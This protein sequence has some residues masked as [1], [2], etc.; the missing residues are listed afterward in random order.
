MFSLTS[1]ALKTTLTFLIFSVLWIAASDW[2]VSFFPLE[3]Q[4]GLQ[5]SKGLIFVAVTSLLIY[6][7]LRF[8]C[9]RALMLEEDLT[10]ALHDLSKAHKKKLALLDSIPISIWDEDYST[11][12]RIIDE[13]IKPNSS[14]ALRHWLD[15]NALAVKEMANSVRINSIGGKTLE[16]FGISPHEI[17]SQ[18]RLGDIFTEKSFRWFK[19]EL[20]AFYEGRNFLNYEDELLTREGNKIQTSTSICLSNSYQDTWES[21]IVTIEDI[22]EKNE[23]QKAIDSF[24]DLD[25]NLHVIVAEDGT[26]LRVNNGWK[27]VL[28]YDQEELVGQS[29]LNLLHPED[30]EKTIAEAK[31]V[32]TGKKTPYFENRFCHKNGEYRYLAWSVTKHQN[33]NVIYAVASDISERKQAEEKLRDAALIINST[34]EGVILTNLEG[35]I[36]EVNAAFTDITGYARDEAIGK[37]PSLLRSGRHDEHFYRQLW[38]EVQGYGYWRGEIWNRKKDGEIY[39]ELLTINRVINQ[40]GKTYGYAGIF[41][42]ISQLKST[43]NRL[44]HL[45]THDV[46]TGLA[47]RSLFQDHLDRAIKHA[48]RTS[49]IVAVILLDL[50]NFKFINDSLGFNKGDELLKQTADRIVSVVRQDDTVA[51]ISSDE[52]A[53]LLEDVAYSK[54]IYKI[55]EQLLE[56]LKEPFQIDSSEIYLT[57]SAGISLYPHDSENVLTLIRN[58]DTALTCA[59]NDGTGRYQFYSEELTT[60]AQENLQIENA[61]R[62]ALKKNQLFLVYQPQ[63]NLINGHLEGFEVLLRW[64]HPLLGM[65]PP[66]KFI[67]IAERSN[68]INEIGEWVLK[69]ACIQGR[70][71][72]D[73]GYEFGRI[74]VNISTPQ[75]MRSNAINTITNILQETA[76]PPEHLELEVTETFAMRDPEHSNG[77]LA[78]F[79]EI[80]IEIAIDDFGTG[81]SSLNYLKKLP[82]DKLKIDQSFVAGMLESENDTAIVNTII[83]LGKALALKIIAEGIETEEQ[84]KQL[85]KLGCQL[86]QGYHYS[87][88]QTAEVIEKQLKA[89]LHR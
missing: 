20:I 86:G 6:L 3:L 39:P 19:E 5:T 50:D 87:K 88:P 53:I 15:N 30:Q 71:W 65:V 26:I 85:E 48:M 7:V 80:G 56:K 28:G 13:E 9:N 60:A 72:L 83:A 73:K 38:E 74:A 11:V 49:K 78:K 67:P 2:V 27:T 54:Q 37:T 44:L 82:I 29:F 25:M 24:F 75:I 45:S 31:S 23:S 41:S 22:S 1:L 69:Q 32:L 89:D 40:D 34:S 16:T 10:C 8:S 81:Y 68:L 35:Q 52:Y 79:R 21:V 63:V 76:F 47:N 42:D 59:K 62:T 84:A 12:K 57:A 43:E 18:M 4:R 36:T 70:E 58:A 33:S 46:L 14:A 66:S 55:I 77:I 61:L 64:H 51:R 17:L